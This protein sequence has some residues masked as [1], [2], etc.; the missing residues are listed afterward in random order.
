M[1]QTRLVKSL[2][3]LLGIVAHGVALSHVHADA[4]VTAGSHLSAT[5]LAQSFASPAPPISA[6]HGRASQLADS[7]HADRA[8]HCTAALGP[9]MSNDDD[10]HQHSSRPGVDVETCFTCRSQQDE[11][12][13]ADARDRLPLALARD[14]DE[15]RTRDTSLKAPTLGLPDLRAPPAIA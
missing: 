12:F 3:A 6:P 8:D 10:H 4:D 7:D 13:A 14:A 2:T 1:R 9:K 15:R 5:D 11:E